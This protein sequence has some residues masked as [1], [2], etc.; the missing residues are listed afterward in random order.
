MTP[1]VPAV[2]P[3]TE[4]TRI[5]RTAAVCLAIAEASGP[6]KTNPPS[7]RVVGPGVYGSADGFWPN[8]TLA[9]EPDG[10]ACT[11]RQEPVTDREPGQAGSPLRAPDLV[12]REICTLAPIRASK[13][14]N[15]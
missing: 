15:V 6:G 11:P 9:D 3:S 12:S 7:V 14:A 2:P 5:R 8:V 13:R 4:T 1:R 10:A